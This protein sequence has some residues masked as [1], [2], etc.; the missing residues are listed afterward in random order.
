MFDAMKPKTTME[1]IDRAATLLKEHGAVIEELKKLSLELRKRRQ[2][3]SD[4][5]TRFPA[6]APVRYS[7]SAGI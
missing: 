6:S 2:E 1:L 5:H 7:T 4:L 3:I